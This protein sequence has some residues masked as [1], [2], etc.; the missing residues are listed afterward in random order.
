MSPNKPKHPQN[1]PPATPNEKCRYPE[2]TNR[3]VYVEPGVQID[4]VK[5][6]VEKYESA[7]EDNTT[8]GGKVLFWTK[9]SA[10]LLLIYVGLTL[11]QAISSHQSLMAIRDQFHQD[12]RPYISITKYEIMDPIS[13]H[14]K[15]PQIF[16][17]GKGIHV[18]VEFKNVGKT[19]AVNMIP[20]YHLVFGKGVIDQIKTEPKDVG[21]QGASVDPGGE[22]SV[23]AISLNDTFSRE[24]VAFNSADVMPWDGS[25]PVIIFGRI[26]YQDISGTFYCNP[27][28]VQYTDRGNWANLKYFAGVS[29]S[30]L[31]QNE[32]R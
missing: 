3:H 8:H 28:L 5:G 2:S 30:G 25:M 24:T 4:F 6:I 12:Q 17:V 23:T 27:I 21:A 15:E 9:I 11:W 7:Q 19:V 26:S 31:C 29:P 32:N 18:N 1:N 22:G 16:E 10:G 13:G 20:H 14:R